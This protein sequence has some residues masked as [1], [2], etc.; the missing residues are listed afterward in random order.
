MCYVRIW[1]IIID[2]FREECLIFK[3][4]KSKDECRTVNAQV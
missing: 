3:D 2:Y 4:I 1:L